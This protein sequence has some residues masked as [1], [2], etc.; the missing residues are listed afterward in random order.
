MLLKSYPVDDQD[1]YQS[2]P[3]RWCFIGWQL[4]VEC[5][6][7][8]PVSEYFKCKELGTMFYL[9]D[10]EFLNQKKE[11]K[12]QRSHRDL[13]SINT[14]SSLYI[15][16]VQGSDQ[17]PTLSN[18]CLTIEQH[19]TIAGGENRK[20]IKVHSRCLKYVSA[21]L[22]QFHKMKGHNTDGKTQ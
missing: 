18:G 22:I 19:I 14:F 13:G 7:Y 8:L 1:Y 20:E 3:I 21:L 16:K 10:S 6:W 17:V 5:V 2:L 12:H 15:L 9:A 4:C 11:S